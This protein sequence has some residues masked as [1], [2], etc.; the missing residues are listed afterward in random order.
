MYIVPCTDVLQ[1]EDHV[2]MRVVGTKQAYVENETINLVCVHNVSSNECPTISWSHRDNPMI[3]TGP[4]LTLESPS[5]KQAGLYCCS[6]NTSS[7]NRHEACLQVDIYPNIDSSLPIIDTVF[8]QSPNESV[9]ILSSLSD[10]YPVAWFKNGI[11]LEGETRNMLNLPL[12]DTQAVYGMYQCFVS[13]PDHPKLTVSL[14][15]LMP[16]GE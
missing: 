5:T 10:I 2:T 6:L 11:Y 3:A 1:V 14:T 7:G 16:Q 13:V 4:V 12:N 15:R 9:Q 8:P